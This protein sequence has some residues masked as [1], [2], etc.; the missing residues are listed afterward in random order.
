MQFSDICSTYIPADWNLHSL[1]ELTTKIGSGITPT[2]GE[3]VYKFKGHPFVR[4]QNVGNGSLLLDNIVYID[5]RIHNRFRSTEIK[6]GDVLLNITGASIGRSAVAND[7]LV[8]GN[9]NQHVCILRPNNNILNPHFLSFFLLSNQGQKQIDSYQAGG[10]RQGL[11]NNQVRS[12]KIPV[13][14]IDE[15]RAIAEVLIDV[16]NLLL[17]LEELI[18]KKR[19]I[20]QAVMQALLLD[21]H[22][23]F[24][25]KREWKSVQLNEL[26]VISR[27]SMITEKEIII[28]DIPV[29]AGGREPAYYHNEANRIGKTITI[30]GSGENAGFVNFYTVPIFAS[31]CSTISEGKKY[32]IEF[33]YYLLHARQKEIYSLQT[34]GTLPHVHP[35][36]LLKIFIDIPDLDTQIEIANIISEIDLEIKYL[37][38]QWYKISNL[39]KAMMQALLTGAIRLL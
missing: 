14:S 38:I 11:N 15:Q 8:G 25:L 34:G 35:R 9:I 28:G 37:E 5:D 31:D 22:K 19:A 26:A 10:N 6:S 23:N 36:D 16:D 17:S 30:S 39:K 1:G 29:V 18:A 33:L 2:G 7:F 12:I 32:S 27:G 3:K 21:N 13:P 4:S 24:P 20:K